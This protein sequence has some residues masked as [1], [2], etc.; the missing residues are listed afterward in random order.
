MYNGFEKIDLQIW[1][2]EFSEP[3]HYDQL[4]KI[5]VVGDSGVGK[6]SF[7][8]GLADKNADDHISTIGLDFVSVQR[9][10]HIIR[11]SYNIGVHAN[12]NKTLEITQKD[13]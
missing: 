12:K 8:L 7:V 13:I 2:K 6:T 4:L 9:S 1:Q 10:L 11:V 5:T 3:S